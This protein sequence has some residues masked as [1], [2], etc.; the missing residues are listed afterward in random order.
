MEKLKPR[1]TANFRKYTHK[2]HLRRTD[3][4][5]T[6]DRDRDRD[7]DRDTTA[8]HYGLQVLH[9]SGGTAR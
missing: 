5:T 7:H 9:A 3:S 4:L 2:K 6:C 8:A 1:S